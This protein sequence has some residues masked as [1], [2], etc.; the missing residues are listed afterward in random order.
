[1]NTKLFIFLSATLVLSSVLRANVLILIDV[2]DVSNVTFTATGAAPTRDETSQSLL[3]GVSLLN[4]LTGNRESFIGITGNFSPNGAEAFTGASL[5]DA[6]NTDSPGPG[7][8]VNLST[9]S[10]TTMNFLTIVSASSG[11]SNIDLSAQSSVLPAVG[12]TGAIRP[13]LGLTLTD[14]IGTYEVVPEPSDSGLVFGLLALA[15]ARWG[16]RRSR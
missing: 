4:F 1:M 13:G 5:I 12:T 16:V 7:P 2:S 9:N 6:E 11:S 10:S 8:D 3:D 14:S 15:A